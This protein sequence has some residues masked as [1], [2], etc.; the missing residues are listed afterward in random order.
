MD[1]YLSLIYRFSIGT[2]N[3]K[4]KR[5]ESLYLSDKIKKEELVLDFYEEDFQ[6]FLD[7]EIYRPIECKNKNKANRS[8][9]DFAKQINDLKM[10]DILTHKE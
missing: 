4:M 8:P 7:I 3:M 6:Y 1:Y 9:L 5:V 10:I 2:S